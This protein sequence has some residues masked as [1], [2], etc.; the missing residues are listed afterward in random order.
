MSLSVLGPPD[1]RSH[2]DTEF[3]EQNL[4]FMRREDGVHEMSSSLGKVS[5]A[6]RQ[7]ESVTFSS[8]AFKWLVSCFFKIQSNEH[9]S[10]VFADLQF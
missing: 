9:N 1:S 2:K 7:W 4:D 3:G 8:A 10:A 5:E 6:N